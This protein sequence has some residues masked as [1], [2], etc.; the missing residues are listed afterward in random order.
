MG[1]GCSSGLSGF[2]LVPSS[3]KYDEALSGSAVDQGFLY[4]TYC[5]L[6]VQPSAMSFLTCAPNPS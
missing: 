2:L 6:S 3:G 4:D 5:Q 1:H